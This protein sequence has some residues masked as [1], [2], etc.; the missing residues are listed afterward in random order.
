[1]RERTRG[2]IALLVLFLAIVGVRLPARAADRRCVPL[3]V[4]L[5]P[6]RGRLDP[7]RAVP[8]QALAAV[9]GPAGPRVA[10]CRC[11]A[12]CE[13]IVSAADVVLDPLPP[14]R[15]WGGDLDAAT[16]PSRGSSGS[17]RTWPVALVAVPILL[18]G[19]AR[20][21]RSRP[22]AAPRALG[23]CCSSRVVFAVWFRVRDV[24]LLLPLQD[25]WR[26]S[27]RSSLAIAA[28]GAARLPRRR[29]GATSALA[30]LAAHRTR[31]RPTRR[32]AGRST[33]CRASTLA[34]RTID[35]TCPPGGRSA[36]TSTPSSRTGSRSCCTASRCAR[37]AR[38]WAPATRTCAISAQGRLHPHRGDSARVPADA[39]G[40]PVAQLEAFTLYRAPRR[41]G[42][43]ST[44]RSGWSRP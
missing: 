3:A 26:S 39:T 4:V 24:R 28:A 29:A 13:K 36:W 9:D 37:S 38:C 32:S 27:R 35:A 21:A 8:R 14:L 40:A 6:E 12:S 30:V 18:R 2:G 5:W 15:N 31:V 7:A 10:A 17:T 22:A 19:L 43:A 34:L 20:A 44:A 11:A 33:S 41:P 23:R 1:M 25:R 16:S 42:R